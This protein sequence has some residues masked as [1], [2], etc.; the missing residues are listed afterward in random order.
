VD[1]VV[2]HQGELTL[3]ETVQRLAAGKG[4]DLVGGCWF[5]RNGRIQQN[6]DRPNAPL[7]NL[8]KPAYD[9]V[10][11]DA[12][13]ALSGERTLPYATSVG[14]PY[15]CSYCTDAVFYNRRFNAYALVVS[16]RRLRN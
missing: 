10:D 6:P 15:D 5:K 9:L 4:L 8:P 2:L 16:P 14:C 1:A 3:L 11:F 13:E 12:Y 7:S